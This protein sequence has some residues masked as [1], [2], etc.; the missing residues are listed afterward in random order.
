[1]KSI[2]TKQDEISSEQLFAFVL[3][4]ICILCENFEFSL[5]TFG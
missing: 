5:D 3:R 4:T 2:S 1:M